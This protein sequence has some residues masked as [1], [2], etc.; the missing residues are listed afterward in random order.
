MSADQK[1]EFL[2]KSM[3]EYMDTINRKIAEL[4]SRLS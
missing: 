4:E 2:K 3:T 1:M